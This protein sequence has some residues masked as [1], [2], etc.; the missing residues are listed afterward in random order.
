M[1]D[2][3]LIDLI[4]ELEMGTFEDD[5]IEQD[6]ESFRVRLKAR[7]VRVFRGIRYN[8]KKIITITMGIF[9]VFALAFSVIALIS[10]KR[11]HIKVVA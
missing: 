1:K 6:I 8:I 2:R 3:Y 7:I 10:K 5:E 11:K 4:G 9:A